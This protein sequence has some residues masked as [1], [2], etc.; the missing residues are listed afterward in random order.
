MILI[1]IFIHVKKKFIQRGDFISECDGHLYYR[2][3]LFLK[4]INEQKYTVIKD[5]LNLRG[6]GLY[7]YLPF[8]NLVKYKKA[9]FYFFGAFKHS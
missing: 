4:Y 5:E 9:I 8:G 7:C 3:K 2:K 6:G 1:I